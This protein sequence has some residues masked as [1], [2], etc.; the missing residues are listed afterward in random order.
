[1]W[2]L[3]ESG[4]EGDPPKTQGCPR[5]SICLHPGSD[6]WAPFPAQGEAQGTADST[7]TRALSWPRLDF[8][9]WH[10]P[11]LV[12]KSWLGVPLI[13]AAW[14]WEVTLPR[15]P[16]LSWGLGVSL[17]TCSALTTSAFKLGWTPL[18]S[19]LSSQLV[20]QHRQGPWA[21]SPQH[22]SHFRGGGAL[23]AHWRWAR[24]QR[25]EVSRGGLLLRS[26]AVGPGG[27]GVP[28]SDGLGGSSMLSYREADVAATRGGFPASPQ[29]K[30]DVA[31][32]ACRAGLPW[33]QGVVL[34]PASPNERAA[35]LCRAARLGDKKRPGVPSLTG[36]LW[37]FSWGEAHQI[38]GGARSP[39]FH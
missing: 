16:T 25:G 24:E 26:Q 14:H 32:E 15:L 10:W 4:T 1:M 23:P 33:H 30:R 17:L 29:W 18:S 8:S 22:D 36:I 34:R 27:S 20:G 35:A 11:A 31:P 37:C 28:T 2:V 12:L 6:P 7:S 13:T 9:D 21:L 38:R 5:V 39:A 3:T 19:R